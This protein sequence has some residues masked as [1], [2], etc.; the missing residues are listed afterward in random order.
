MPI[1]SADPNL[2][3][4]AFAPAPS[5][6]GL[7]LQPFRGLRYAEGI[8]LRAVTS[9]PYDVIDADGVAAL[10]QSSATLAE[11]EQPAKRPSCT[12]TLPV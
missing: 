8:D 9:P 10:E 2:P 3:V 1:M 12:D 7:V 11:T 6:D 5:A 4:L